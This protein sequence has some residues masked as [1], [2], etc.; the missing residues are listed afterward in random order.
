MK[1]GRSPRLPDPGDPTG[2]G[3]L[4]KVRELTA[5]H[6]QN[7]AEALSNIPNVLVSVSVD[8]DTLVDAQ[9]QERKYDA[10]QFPY[11]TVEENENETSN[12]TGPG[13]EPGAGANVPK[14]V[15]QPVTTKNARTLEKTRTASDS[16][17]AGTRVTTRRMAGFTPKSVQVAVSI[18]RDYYRDVSVREGLSESDKPALTARIAQLKIETEKEV[19][20]KV[21]KLIPPPANGT[22]A[23]LI[24]VSSY[25]PLETVEPP[26]SVPVATRVSDAVTQWGGPAGLALF[27]LW[28]LWMLNRSAK[29]APAGAED[30]PAGKPIAGR[31]AGAAQPSAPGEEED[32]ELPKEPTKRDKLQ[33]LVKDNPEMAAAVLSRWLSPPK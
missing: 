27:A 25:T 20:E 16:V 13:S 14:A 12:E 2:T 26:I 4:E 9:E 21:A 32:D 19:R 8:V 18:P 28:A 7:I 5:F 1:S 3:Y 10:K 22:A 23:E 29:R 30:T 15:R 31:A 24:N 17:P 6:Q 33:T 11:K